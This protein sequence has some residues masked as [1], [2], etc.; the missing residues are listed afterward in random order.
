MPPETPDAQTHQQPVA[1]IA[2]GI[3][4]LSPNKED[5]LLIEEDDGEGVDI[6]LTEADVAE[7]PPPLAHKGEDFM[8]EIDESGVPRRVSRGEALQRYQTEQTVRLEDVRRTVLNRSTTKRAPEE[9]LAAIQRNLESTRRE[10]YE[11]D[12]KKPKGANII[13]HP[14]DAYKARKR[15][16][17]LENQYQKLLEE[18][19]A[20]REKL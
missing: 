1:P 9:F 2:E 12:Q 16:S 20:A 7:E 14:I 10:I 19:R 5:A 15:R 4:Y 18:D 17:A 11:L 13:L 8:T 3:P 6:Q